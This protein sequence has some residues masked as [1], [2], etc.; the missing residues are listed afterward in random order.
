MDRS[1]LHTRAALV[2]A[3]TAAVV[4]STTTL[5][6]AHHAADDDQLHACVTKADGQLR[7]LQAGGAC[8]PNE[9]PV[10]WSSGS[11]GLEAFKAALKASDSTWGDTGLVH[12][13]NLFALPTV[14]ADGEVHFSELTG[15]LEGGPG[16]QLR[17][18]TITGDDLAGHYGPVNGSPDLV[19]HIMGAVTGEKIADGSV[20]TRDLM[21]GAVTADKLEL[22]AVRFTDVDFSTLGLL[23]GDIDAPANAGQALVVGGQ[24]HRVMV[25]SQ[26]QITCVCSG[27]GDSAS[28]QYQLVRVSDPGSVSPTYDPVSPVYEAL[29]RNGH[30]TVPVSVSA[31]DTVDAGDVL[32][33]LRVVSAASGTAA[34][35]ARN[36]VVN[37]VVIGPA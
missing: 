7:L 32:Y 3:V 9:M 29:L 27:A 28:V 17:D 11:D 31:L 30:N 18:G 25:T 20:E 34:P 26:A 19:E 13:S 5:A 2:I 36:T 1:F 4:I 10:Q 33:R 23:T 35:S 14:L 22:P 24:A 21:D 16:G 15:G 8:R 6:A 12:W 37:A